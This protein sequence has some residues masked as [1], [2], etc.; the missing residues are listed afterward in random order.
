M[1]YKLNCGGK[2]PR[3]NNKCKRPKAQPLPKEIGGT[4]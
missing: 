4:G 2:G 1:A 3:K